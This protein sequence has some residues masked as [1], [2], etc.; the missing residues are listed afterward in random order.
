MWHGLIVD[1]PDG[2]VLCDGEN[3]TPDL[4]A[5]FVIGAAAGFD[6]GGT[7]G[8]FQHK[9]T[10]L[11][12]T[13]FTDAV[14]THGFEG[15]TDTPGAALFDYSPTAGLG[16]AYLYHTHAFAGETDEDGSFHQHT[17]G[18]DSSYAVHIPPF[19]TMLFIMKT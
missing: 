2:W 6:P 16:Q 9:H 12:S 15:T 14:H 11:G 4:R 10:T 8:D 19:Y 17:L 18:I 1:I 13:H 5:K 3:G 7:G